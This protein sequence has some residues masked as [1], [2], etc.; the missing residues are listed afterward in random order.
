MDKLWMALGGIIE[1]TNFQLNAFINRAFDYLIP[2]IKKDLENQIKSQMY[3]IDVTQEQIDKAMGIHTV[4]NHSYIEEYL[5][6]Q[7]YKPKK[8]EITR[9]H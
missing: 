2:E 5:K 3:Q 4:D 7:E 8:W 6:W 9:G 1:S